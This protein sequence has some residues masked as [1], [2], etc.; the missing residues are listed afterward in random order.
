MISFAFYCMSSVC[1]S[2]YFELHNIN[3]VR[4]LTEEAAATD[5]H[6]WMS[7]THYCMGFLMLLCPKFNEFR[8]L[9]LFVLLGQNNGNILHLY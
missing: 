5:I 4:S 1:K 3:S 7:V 6:A 2:A 8:I 9:L